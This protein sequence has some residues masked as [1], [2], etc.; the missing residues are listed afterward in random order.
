MRVSKEPIDDQQVYFGAPFPLVFVAE[1][2]HASEEESLAWLKES[3][4]S[5]RLELER[6]GAILFR[7]FP[8]RTDQDFDGFVSALNCPNFRYRDSLSNAVRVNR[9][10]RVFTANEA[11]PDVTIYLHHEMAQT[12]IYPSSLFFFCEQAAETGGATPLCRSDVLLERMREELPEFVA[13]CSERGLRYS[14]VMPGENDRSSGMGRS[15]QSTLDCESREG[16]EA[17]LRELN[18]EWSWEADNCLRV[19]TPRLPAV[20]QLASG[21]QAFF[22][23]LIAA[24]R[25]WKDSRND[26][27]KAITYGDGSP[28]D[29]EAVL[30]AASIA[31]EL[32]FDVSWQ[33]GDVAW[34]DNFS[35]MHGRRSFTGTRKV[36]A[37]LVA[38]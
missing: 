28:L 22:N 20:R 23:Q 35:T 27:S 19:T 31:D 17:R 3:E 21:R 9:T 36:L 25:G 33:Q 34:V 7:G 8:C 13:N 16:A 18:Y 30:A 1:S 14:N 10:E 4:E 26:P 6:H 29:R 37:S 32:S 24:F 15:W 38:A 5:L 12:P 2:H 11:P